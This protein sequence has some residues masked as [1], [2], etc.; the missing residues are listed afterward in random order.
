MSQMWIEYG[1]R[2]NDGRVTL[3]SLRCLPDEPQPDVFLTILDGE[4]VTPVRRFVTAGEWERIE[5]LENWRQVP[6]AGGIVDP[7]RNPL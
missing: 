5:G 4:P 7:E 1:Y 3:I 2:N 6:G